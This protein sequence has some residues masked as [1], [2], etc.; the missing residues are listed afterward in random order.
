M[1]AALLCTQHEHA[2]PAALEIEPGEV[3]FRVQRLDV[4]LAVAYFNNQQA[5]LGQMIRRFGEHPSHQVQTVIAA[6]Q[7]QFRF[8]LVFIR[9]VGEIFR[10]DVGRVRH[11]QVETLTRQTVKTIALNGVHPLIHA[12][13]L[14]V[15]VGHLHCFERQASTTSAFWNS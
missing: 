6:G 9:H 7:A 1:I 5:L 12:V 13:T 4:H 10:I 2:M 11:D 3:D 8:M 15:L 14:N